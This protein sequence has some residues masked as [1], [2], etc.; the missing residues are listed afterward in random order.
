MEMEEKAKSTSN[1]A[2]KIYASTLGILVGLAGVEHGIFESLQGNVRPQG[3]MI[4]AI[5][6]AQK[7]WDYAIET[8]LTII[9]NFLISGILAMF[10]GVLV[11]V[12]AYAYVERK[13]GAVVLLVL[14]TLLFFVGGGFAP[15]FLTVLAFIAATRINKPLTFW[16]SRIPAGPRRLIAKLWPWS[17]ILSVLFFVVAVEIA[18]FGYP[19]LGFFEPETTYAIQFSLGFAMLIL[20]IVALPAANAH[21][22]QRHA[23]LTE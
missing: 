1:R 2:T 4:D 8:A 19:L 23:D 16:R 18:I 7:M 6:P 12:W 9:P 15:I 17:F 21:D 14:S 13:Y 11:T 5:G 10:I 20:A 3:I 22:A